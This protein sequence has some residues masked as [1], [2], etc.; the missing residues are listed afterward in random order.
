MQYV[1]VH[2]SYTQFLSKLHTTPRGGGRGVLQKWSCLLQR[3][4]CLEMAYMAAC[5]LTKSD[6]SIH[7]GKIHSLVSMVWVL[8]VKDTLSNELHA[9]GSVFLHSGCQVGTLEG[10][11]QYAGQEWP[12]LLHAVVPSHLV[13]QPVTVM[14]SCQLRVLVSAKLVRSGH[15]RPM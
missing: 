1:S 15:H 4:H 8:T 5:V 10:C 2:C 14:Y 6:P 11:L 13:Q 9:V 12:P 3:A 7:E